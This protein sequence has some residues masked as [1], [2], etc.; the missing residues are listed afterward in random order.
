[1]DKCWT[2]I[3]KDCETIIKEDDFLS[4]DLEMIEQMCD[5]DTLDVY[6]VNLYKALVRWSE[7]ECRRRSL[8]VTVENQR[9]ILATILPKVRFPLMTQEDFATMVVP[10]KVLRD[11]QTLSMFV[12]FNSE[13]K[14]KV[15]YCLTSRKGSFGEEYYA[16]IISMISQVYGRT[17]FKVDYDIYLTAIGLPTLEKSFNFIDF[18]FGYGESPVQ[19]QKISGTRISSDLLYR[20]NLKAPIL[21]T[22]GVSHTFSVSIYQSDLS[23][24]HLAF[25]KTSKVYVEKLGKIIS[26]EFD[27]V[28]TLNSKF[29]ENFDKHRVRLF[30]KTFRA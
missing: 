12:W 20:F 6:E 26:F 15:E 2:I 13:T 29:H 17:F 9:K 18:G 23:L 30:F 8:E 24:K 5:R 25:T 22:K 28:H 4:A 16:N 7:E 10:G 3:D 14:P 21:I 19:W 1:M 11:N 27:V